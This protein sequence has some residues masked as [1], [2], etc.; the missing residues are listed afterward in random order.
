MYDFPF[1]DNGMFISYIFLT[2][3]TNHQTVE[4]LVIEEYESIINSGVTTEELRRAI[5]QTKAGVAFSRDGSYAVAS[6]LNEAIAI[7]DW[8]YYT[9]FMKCI[10]IVSESNI[11]EAA[12]EYLIEDNSTTGWFV[13]KKVE[14]I[15]DAV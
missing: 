10:D 5:A 13:P 6:A 8:T 2:P 3:E 7:G 4:D 12:E 11:Q 14:A 15:Q 9:T 1:K